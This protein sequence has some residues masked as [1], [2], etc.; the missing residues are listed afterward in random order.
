M[1]VS[2]YLVQLSLL[3]LPYV[4]YRSFCRCTHASALPMVSSIRIVTGQ[5]PLQDDNSV[6]V[7]HK[8]VFKLI[9]LCDN[10]KSRQVEVHFIWRPV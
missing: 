5:H 1:G 3:L 8:E 7:V 10:C 6:S 4:S 9:P 2:A